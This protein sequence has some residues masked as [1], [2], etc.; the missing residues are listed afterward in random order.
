L[1]AQGSGGGSA[2]VRPSTIL[3]PLRLLHLF[4]SETLHSAFVI[5]ALLEQ[6]IL[7][8]DVSSAASPTVASK[9]SFRRGGHASLPYKD[10]FDFG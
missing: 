4:T 8:D 5:P 2:H 1:F 6:Q 7:L 3:H 10:L 9:S